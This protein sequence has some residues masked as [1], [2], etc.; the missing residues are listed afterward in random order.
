MLARPQPDV[1]SELTPPGQHRDLKP[2]NVLVS[3]G[4]KAKIS[5]FGE[6]RHYALQLSTTPNTFKA[7]QYTLVGTANYVDP[8]IVRGEE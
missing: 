2:E 6:A 4:M 5:D 8:R 7:K 3:A 1:S